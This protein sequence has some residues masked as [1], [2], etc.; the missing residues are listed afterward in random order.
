MSKLREDIKKIVSKIYLHGTGDLVVHLSKEASD[1]IDFFTY[2]L[3]Q[4]FKDTVERV[5]GEDEGNDC[6]EHKDCLIQNGQDK[7]RKEQR[8][9]LS[10]IL[11]EK[12]VRNISTLQYVQPTIEDNIRYHYTNKY[13]NCYQTSHYYE[14]QKEIMQEFRDKHEALFKELKELPSSRGM[15]LALTKL[16]ES[17]MWLN[18]ALTKND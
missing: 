14:E 6:I 11:S 15:S 12:E 16:E 1:E 4:L 8:Q 17:A 10:K 2:Q 9:N 5:I 7:M 18:K 13:K 3:L